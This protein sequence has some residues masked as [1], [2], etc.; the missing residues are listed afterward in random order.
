MDQELIAYLDE[1]FAESARRIESLREE[2]QEQGRHTHVQ[3]EAL[4]DDIRLIAEGVMGVDEKLGDFRVSVEKEFR[5]VRA[6][7]SPAYSGLDHRI[8]KLEDWRERKERDP[9][10]IIRERFGSKADS[11]S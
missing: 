9:I 10:E 1:R 4:R 3:I 2:L 11:E 8:R 7:I 5:E 6:L